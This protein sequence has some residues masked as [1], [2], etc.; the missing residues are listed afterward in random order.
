MLCLRCFEYKYQNIVI[1]NSLEI[2]VKMLP[3]FPVKWFWIKIYMKAKAN[4]NQNYTRRSN[5]L[6]LDCIWDQNI[7]FVYLSSL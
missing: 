3:Y 7:A 6:I 5:K 4:T 1:A 2:S